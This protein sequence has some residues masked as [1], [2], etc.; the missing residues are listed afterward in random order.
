MYVSD[1]WRGT[2]VAEVLADEMHDFLSS[3]KCRGIVVIADNPI[4]ARMAE[5][6]G[7]KKVESPVYIMVGGSEGV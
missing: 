3:V 7:M 2:G 1:D 5:S 4:V 6:H